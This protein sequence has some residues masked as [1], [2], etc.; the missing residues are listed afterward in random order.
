MALSLT[1][2]SSN[3]KFPKYALKKLESHNAIDECLAASRV[4]FNSNMNQ[5]NFGGID[6]DHFGKYHNT[7]YLSPQNLHKY[8]SQFL[9]GLRMVPRENKNNVYAKFGGTNKEYYGTFRNSV[10]EVF[11]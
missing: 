3:L 7:L 8:C 6:I 5:L 10:Y 1:L 9:L 2:P 4:R 11:T